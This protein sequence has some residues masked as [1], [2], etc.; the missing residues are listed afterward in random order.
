MQRIVAQGF[1]GRRFMSTFNA[2]RDLITGL[3]DKDA[4]SVLGLIDGG[5]TQDEAPSEFRAALAAVRRSPDVSRYFLV[6][7]TQKYVDEQLHRGKG[8]E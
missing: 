2:D 3:T 7:K 5:A 8:A 6:A 4:H 1:Y